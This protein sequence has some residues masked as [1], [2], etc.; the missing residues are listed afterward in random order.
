MSG[1]GNDSGEGMIANPKDATKS[2]DSQDSMKSYMKSMQTKG[3]KPGM[4]PAA[5]STPSK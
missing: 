4:K 5:P 1:C 2:Q 3:M